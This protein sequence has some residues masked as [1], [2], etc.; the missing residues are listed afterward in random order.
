MRALVLACIAAG[1]LSLSAWVA[2]TPRSR[3]V[4]TPDPSPL[5]RAPDRCNARGAQ[6]RRGRDLE[7]RAVADEQSY[8]FHPARGRA[9]LTGYLE[10][11]RCFHESSDA[12]GA[13]R[14]AERATRLHTQ[15]DRDYHDHR[16]RLAHALG[17]DRKRVARDECAALLMLLEGHDD[18]YVAWLRRL[19]REL[20]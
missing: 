5:V 15:L 8:R 16:V 10:A 19:L 3:S 6:A 12:A 14:V 17:A 20:E 9:A 4:R 13:R 18:E 11:E 7:L 2:A 1:L